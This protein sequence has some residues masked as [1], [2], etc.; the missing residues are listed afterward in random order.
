MKLKKIKVPTSKQARAQ[1]LAPINFYKSPALKFSNLITEE[2]G[3]APSRK[4]VNSARI[5][6]RLTSDNEQEQDQEPVK[7]STR[8]IHLSLA[9]W[10]LISSYF[11]MALNHP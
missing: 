1:L 7:F 10:Q 3:E 2:P 5:I 8:V 4:F 11:S 6:R 9:L